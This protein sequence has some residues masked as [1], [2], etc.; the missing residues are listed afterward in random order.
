M[1]KARK[2]AKPSAARSKAS[3]SK[4]STTKKRSQADSTASLET[5]PLKRRKAAEAGRAKVRKLAEE[6]ISDEEGILDEKVEDAA[7]AEPEDG[8]SDTEDL[9]NHHIEAPT[10][11]A[12][13]F[14][15]WQTTSQ[16]AS[17]GKLSQLY[18]VS[19]I[20]DYG[21]IWC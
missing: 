13:G 2:R 20:G 9:E 11:V 8:N 4:T 5:R 10:V 21:S 14:R 15:L 6:A 17:R 16:L 12:P 18:K 3:L 19:M 1:A 7:G